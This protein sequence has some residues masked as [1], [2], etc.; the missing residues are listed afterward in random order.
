MTKGILQPPGNPFPPTVI[1]AEAITNIGLMFAH[2]FIL[3]FFLVLILYLFMKIVNFL[4]ILVVYMFSLLVGLDSFTHLH[5]P[6]SP[7]FEI[8][9]LMFQTTIFLLTAFNVYDNKIKKR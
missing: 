5:T 1:E 9:F 7:L 6:F 3:V 8:F 4:P 2:L